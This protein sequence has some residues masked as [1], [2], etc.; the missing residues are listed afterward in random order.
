MSKR[1]ETYTFWKADLYC[2]IYLIDPKGRCKGYPLL[3]YAGGSYIGGYSDY[4]P[5]YLS[6]IRETTL[7][8][9]ELK[10]LDKL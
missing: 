4:F 8:I 6:L 5:V 1:K 9:T 2:P 3:T 7:K 10:K